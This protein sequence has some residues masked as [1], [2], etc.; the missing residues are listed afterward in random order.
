MNTITKQNALQKIC[1][2]CAYQ[3]RN[4]RETHEKLI[5]YGLNFAETEEI[6][7]YLIKENY[8]NEQR[9]ALQYAGAKFR[10][11]NW[12]KYKIRFALKQKGISDEYIKEALS[13]I[14]ADD[15]YTTLEKLAQQKIASLAKLPVLKIKQKTTAYLLQKGYGNADIQE[16]IKT[17][18]S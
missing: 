4:P 18:L 8:I 9:F 14:D 11:K 12:G 17:L 15:Y 6:M 5:S 2:F 3:E 13:T 7:Q 10:L 1:N 16:I